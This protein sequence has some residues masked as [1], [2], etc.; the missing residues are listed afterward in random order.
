MLYLDHNATTCIHPKVRDFVVTL[1]GEE[2]YNPSSIHSSG[3]NARTIVETARL[4]IAKSVGIDINSREY[5]LVFTSSGTESNNLLMSNYSDGEIFISSIEHLS[6]FAHSKYSNNIKFI[7]V[8]NNGIIDINDLENLLS[9]ST[10]SKKL[11]SVM[12]ANNES[13][14]IQNIKELTIIAKK[15]GADFHSD[16]V[17][18]FGKIPVNIPELGIDFATIS[19]HKVGGM[20]GSSVLI[21]KKNH[22]LKAMM[23]GGG[24]EKNI[25]SGTENVIAIA[26]F[27]L[28]AELV[29][30]E[31]EKRYQQM[32]ILQDYLEI[33]LLKYNDIKIASKNVERLPNTTLLIIA[34]NDPQTKLI[35][36]DLHGVEVS[37]GSACSSGKVGKSHVLKAMGYND[38]ECKSSL[39]ISF[40]HQQTIED[41]KEF[42]KI[43]EQVYNLKIIN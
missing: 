8:D 4:Q 40:N 13:G 3:R 6:I 24:Q 41:V 28:A 10:S 11:L 27:G 22:L 39:R 16:C 5:E 23:I 2:A 1:L 14:V 42:I 19:S 31:I 30:K 18:A 9:A 25:R 43:F 32:K 35:A 21:T 37:S 15:Y 29:R 33:N 12:L 20:Q 36:L 26:S 34:N 17:Q 7:K 38:S